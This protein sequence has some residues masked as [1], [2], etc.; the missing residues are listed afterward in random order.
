MRK[1]EKRIITK[2]VDAIFDIVCNKCGKSMALDGEQRGGMIPDAHSRQEYLGLLNASVDGCYAS[3]DLIDSHRYRFSMC[4]K[5]LVSLFQSF[6]LPPTITEYAMTTDEDTD[7]NIEWSKDREI[8]STMDDEQDAL[9]RWE[10]SCADPIYVTVGKRMVHWFRNTMSNHET[11]EDGLV[12]LHLECMNLAGRGSNWDQ[13][14]KDLREKFGF[15]LEGFRKMNNMYIYLRE[16][17]WKVVERRPADGWGWLKRK[18]TAKAEG[19]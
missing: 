11:R 19:T 3:D 12:V 10:C 13:A 16:P 8:R 5:C 1:I 2:Q 6:A 4:E 7:R 15:Q 9:E 17:H 18:E 14:W